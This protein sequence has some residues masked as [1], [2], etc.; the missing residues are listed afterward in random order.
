MLVGAIVESYGTLSG[1]VLEGLPYAEGPWRTYFN[2]E[3]SIASN[4][5]PHEAMR[6][7]YC[8]LMTDNPDVLRRHHVSF[9][10]VVPYMY[11]TNV[12]FEWLDLLL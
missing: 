7:Y 9:F 5:I 1:E 10:G 12:D 11:V 4:T 3:T 8:G 6:S 2:G